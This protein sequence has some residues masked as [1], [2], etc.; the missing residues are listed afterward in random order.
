MNLKLKNF[1]RLF[2]LQNVS[3]HIHLISLISVDLVQVIHNSH[4]YHISHTKFHH[5]C[6]MNLKI[7]LILRKE[8][9]IYP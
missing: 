7:E 9:Y 2:N 6:Y 5:V 3:I 8:K 4:I 1:F